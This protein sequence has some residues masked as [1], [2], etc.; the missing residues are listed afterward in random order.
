M[1]GNDGEGVGADGHGHEF[2]AGQRNEN[3]PTNLFTKNP[4]E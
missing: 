4:R 3:L 1:L 2:F